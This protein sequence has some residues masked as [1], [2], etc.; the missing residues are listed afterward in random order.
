MIKVG[1]VKFPSIFIMFIE[2]KLEQLEKKLDAILALL[3]EPSEIDYSN[4]KFLCLE[5]VFD[6]VDSENPMMNQGDLYTIKSNNTIDFY[7]GDHYT[8]FSSKELVEKYGDKI[9][10]LTNK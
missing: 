8:T 6:S 2:Q 7:Y 10:W 3:K 9:Q 1:G 5:N 4:R